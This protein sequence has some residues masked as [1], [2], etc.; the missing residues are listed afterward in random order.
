MLNWAWVILNLIGSFGSTAEAVLP[1]I[2]TP[3]QADCGSDLHPP[4][5]AEAAM[6]AIG[7][8]QRAILPEGLICML[9]LRLNA[10][11]PGKPVPIRYADHRFS[12][13]IMIKLILWFIK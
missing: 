9:L 11:V 3:L 8:N 7:L 4:A 10:C 5:T 13:D 1:S 12:F 6:N 2:Q